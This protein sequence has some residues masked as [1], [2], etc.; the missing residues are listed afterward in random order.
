LVVRTPQ[1]GWELEVYG[2]TDDPPP[3]ELSGWGNPLA[4][5]VTIESKEEAIALR[6]TSPNRYFLLWITSL[7]PALDDPGRFRVEISDARLLE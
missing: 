1:P 7:A 4:G 2:S 5:P 3:A 6:A